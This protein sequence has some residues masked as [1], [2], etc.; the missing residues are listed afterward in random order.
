MVPRLRRHLAGNLVGYVALTVALMGVPVAWA[1]GRNTVGTKQIKPNAVRSSDVKNEALTGFD[2]N[3]STFGLVPSAANAGH[4]QTAAN[5]VNAQSAENATNAENAQN[6][7]SA[8][9]AQNAVNAQNANNANSASFALNSQNSD[10]ANNLGGFPLSQFAGI[11]RESGTYGCNADILQPSYE[12]CS[13]DTINL[14]RSGRVLGILTGTA[15]AFNL[16][17]PN[18]SPADNATFVQG[19]CDLSVDTGGTITQAPVTKLFTTGTKTGFAAV[20]VSASLSAGD[21][22]F[23]VACQDQDGDM[24]WENLKFAVVLL[25][26]A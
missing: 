10:N 8:Q 6:A 18:Q 15:I 17:D 23:T 9:N 12:G 21:H 26:S 4:A 2:V 25:G 14:P 24:D 7:G 13:I 1:L 5:A 3:E 11:G 20:G 22:D 16:D 19:R